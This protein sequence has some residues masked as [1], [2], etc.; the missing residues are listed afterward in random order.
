M[1]KG[2]RKKAGQNIFQF[3]N[4]K[5]FKEIVEKKKKQ[6]ASKEYFDTS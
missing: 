3:T 5:L 4:E 1:Q 6:A 2:K